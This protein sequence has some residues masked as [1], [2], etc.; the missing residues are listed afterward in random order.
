MWYHTPG[1][2]FHLWPL[3]LGIWKIS[4]VL[5]I[6]C[7]IC[8]IYH[9]GCLFTF[10]EAQRY[11]E[12]WWECYNAD[13]TYTHFITL[14]AD[15]AIQTKPSTKQVGQQTKPTPVIRPQQPKSQQ[16]PAASTLHPATQN[17]AVKH[18][19]IKCTNHKDHPSTTQLQR[20]AVEKSLQ[21]NSHESQSQHKVAPVP[22]VSTQFQP[23]DSPQYNRDWPVST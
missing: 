18:Y 22:K 6:Q 2:N 20:P 10:V 19:N 11:P 4:V 15:L 14:V 13:I 17:L 5:F 1:R 9:S 16:T 3:Y 8:L 23:R 7:I 12:N 21:Q